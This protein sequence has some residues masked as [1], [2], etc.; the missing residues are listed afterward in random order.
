[1]RKIVFRER[2][3]RRILLDL[4]SHASL[5]SSISIHTRNT[6]TR[7][8]KIDAASAYLFS[9]HTISAVSINL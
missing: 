8:P 6:Y 1:M 2:E 3:K 9:F 4:H 7:I 5:N